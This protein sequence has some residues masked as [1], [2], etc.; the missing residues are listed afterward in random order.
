MKTKP[1]II[2]DIAGILSWL[3]NI[4]QSIDFVSKT[5]IQAN[6]GFVTSPCVAVDYFYYI[7]RLLH[8]DST[9]LM[10]ESAYLWVLLLSWGYNHSKIL[11]LTKT[12]FVPDDLRAMPFGL[13][14][15]KS[16]RLCVFTT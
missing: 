13:S 6:W 12:I 7:N 5:Q 2:L 1:Q 4:S 16:P 15:L 11:I 9:I 14:C 8:Y 3:I 10:I